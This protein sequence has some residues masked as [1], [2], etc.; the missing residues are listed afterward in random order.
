[1]A[2]YVSQING[3][4]IFATRARETES[5]LNIDEALAG[6]ANGVFEVVNLTTGANPH[7]D[8]Q[9]PSHK[10]IYLT[11]ES[12]S[13]K[14]DPYTEWIYTQ[15]NTWEIIGETSIDLSGYKTDQEPVTVSGLGAGKT[16]TA[17]TQNA[18]GE[19]SA[20]AGDIS[21]TSSQISDKSDTYSST[22]T[23]AVTGKAIAAALGTLDAEETS[24]DGTNVQVKV[25]EVDGE[26][27]AVNITTDNTENKNNKVTSWQSTPD[28][29]HYPSEK[30][31]K[32]TIDANGNGFVEVTTS[33]TYAQITAIL[34]DGKIPYIKQT[35]TTPDTSHPSSNAL[36]LIYS[37]RAAPYANATRYVFSTIYNNLE[38]Y[39]SVKNVSPASAQ[40]DPLTRIELQKSNLVTSWSSTVSNTN[41]PSEKLVKDSLDDKV[42][43]VSGK[44]LSTN[45]YTTTEK[46]KL[47]GISEGANKV[48]SSTT[49]GNIKID[50]TETTVY[51]HPTDAGNK[52]IP[53]GGSTGQVLVY[54]GS[55]GTASWGTAPADNTKADKVASATSGNFAGLDSNGN[56]TDSGKKASD[57]ATAAQGSKADSAIQGVEVNGSALTPDSNMVVDILPATSAAYGV[58]Q[59]GY[60]DL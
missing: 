22:G 43:K 1:M 33:N 54:G 25:T 49:N 36:Y 8:V 50:S 17:L 38:Y 44:G 29:T 6:I 53:T 58:V 56:L 55:S 3:N 7:P 5:G 31:V 27:T 28:D 46:N 4:P 26:I 45:D 48:E 23:T 12:G 37:N 19:I 42:D 47:A 57:F 9:D 16:I 32:D 30:L 14:T 34:N 40:W 15:S 2:K 18:N 60:V 59:L 24:S 11:K 35:Y 20:T 52:H 39:I 21:I 51:T 41:Y 13:S 10:I